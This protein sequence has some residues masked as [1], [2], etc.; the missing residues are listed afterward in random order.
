MFSHAMRKEVLIMVA[1]LTLPLNAIGQDLASSNE[2]DVISQVLTFLSDGEQRSAER[3]ILA[4]FSSNPRNQ[5]LAFYYAALMRSRFSME[6]ADKAF[7]Y[8]A[9]LDDSSLY[10]KVS[11]LAI[12]LDARRDVESNFASLEAIVE[13]N[14]TD[15]M[16]RWLLAIECRTFAYD[17]K[18]SASQ[19]LYYKKGA[20]LFRQILSQWKPGP[21]L[22]HQTLA[23]ILDDL[24]LHAEA[25]EHRRIA[26][27][28][29]PTGWS[30]HGLWSTLFKLGQYGE[31]KIAIEHAIECEPFEILYRKNLTDT[32][33]FLN[34][35]HPEALSAPA[36]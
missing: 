27:Q 29:E 11:K 3:L 21:V 6:Q 28:Q 9:S 10:A 12:E 18:P 5:E 33:Q 35:D 16:L 1:V 4:T 34:A 14:P 25:L 36:K 2:N 26:V 31:A 8:A 32:I 30:Y 19:S 15:M 13:Q 20:E 24:D 7:A 22:V 17:R 23:N